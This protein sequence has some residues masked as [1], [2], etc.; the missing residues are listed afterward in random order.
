M[1]RAAAPAVLL[2][3]LLVTAA[4]G[5]LPA[6][7]T[8]PD[9]FVIRASRIFT[10][11]PEGILKDA[12]LL[13]ENGKISRII[14][15]R[16]LPPV[17]VVDHS[18]RTVM[19]CLV[20]AHSHMSVYK[21]V[22]SHT[23]PLTPDLPVLAIFDSYSPEVG[24][25]RRSGIVAVNV[26]PGS[27]N[28]VGGISSILK[29]RPGSGDPVVL[30]GEAFLKVSLNSEV[31]DPE[32]APTSLMGAEAL[33]DEAL[34][35]ACRGSGFRDEILGRRSMAALASGTLRPIVAASSFQEIRTALAWLE[36]WDLD[37]VLLGGEEAEPFIRELKRRN[38]P[39]I[40]AP[41]QFSSPARAAANAAGLLAGG[42][43]MAFASYS[44][45]GRPID[46]RLSAL[47][48]CRNGIAQEE[49]LKTVTIYPAEILGIGGSAGSIEEGKDADLVVLSGDPLDL[50]SRISA[51]YIGGKLATAPEGAGE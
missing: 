39:V 7:A 47:A 21:G 27:G 11:G 37:G 33:L 43:R 41:V 38:I 50:S 5:R 24:E 6:N 29:I 32:K 4:K 1:K 2:S 49:A 51:V 3:A 16:D 14:R 45:E 17:P 40:L 36:R 15:G 46:L 44:P 20:D 25:A 34:R 28:L 18:G 12:S 13:I 31:L 23:G 26:S 10:S 8:E 35:A 48:L 9:V 19:P 22:L 30:R 42:V